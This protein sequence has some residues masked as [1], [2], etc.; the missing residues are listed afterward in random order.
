[1]LDAIHASRWRATHAIAR[2]VVVVVVVVGGAS[3][4]VVV[5]TRKVSPRRIRSRRGGYDRVLD[6]A[7][8]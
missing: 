3:S 6:E 4:A 1:M 2:R 8:R 7:F 5:A